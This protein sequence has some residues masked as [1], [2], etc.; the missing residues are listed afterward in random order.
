M[1]HNI[2]DNKSS[3][4]NGNGEKGNNHHQPTQE[5]Y[6]QMEYL[7]KA[8]DLYANGEIDINEKGEIKAKTKPSRL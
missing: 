5:D 8:C 6:A 3:N 2:A 1:K 4:D 7:K